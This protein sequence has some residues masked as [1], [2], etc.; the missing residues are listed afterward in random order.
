[1]EAVGLTLL[2]LQSGNIPVIGDSL[3]AG[4]LRWAIASAAIL[5][6]CST[7][8]EAAGVGSVRTET[9]PSLLAHIQPVLISR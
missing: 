8:A 7:H 2:R 1:M 4:P 9:Q 6:N 5:G 3:M